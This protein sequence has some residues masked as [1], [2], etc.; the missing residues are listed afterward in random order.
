MNARPQ[1]DAR[2][3]ERPRQKSI[4]LILSR[5]LSSKLATAAF[6]TDEHGELVYFNEAAEELLG[7]PFSET[8]AL[9][10]DE[11]GDLFSVQSLEGTPVP[12]EEMPAGIAR[13]ERRPAH[14]EL[15]ITGGDGV[16]HRIAVTALPLFAHADELVG[17]LSVFWPSP[18]G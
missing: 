12:F 5:E 18:R 7:R 8:A 11:W 14:G 1:Y 2:V 10:P 16:R 13:A 3:V 17:I 9:A 4:V 6:V 15:C